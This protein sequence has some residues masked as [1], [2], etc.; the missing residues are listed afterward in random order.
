[1]GELGARLV[2]IWDSPAMSR[3]PAADQVLAVLTLLARQP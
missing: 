1:M 3:A 2:P